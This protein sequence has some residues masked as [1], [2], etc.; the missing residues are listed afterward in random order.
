MELHHHHHHHHHHH[1]TIDGG[2]ISL[3]S[4]GNDFKH[5]FTKGNMEHAA[6]AA[7]PAFTT[8]VGGVMG[9]PLGAAAGAATGYL[10]DKGLQNAIHGTGYKKSH[11][12]YTDEYHETIKANMAAARSKKG[13]PR[14]RFVKGSQ[15]AR[16]HMAK[17]RAMRTSSQKHVTVRKKRGKKTNQE[18]DEWANGVE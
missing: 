16:D 4:I 13:P 10:A 7:I 1:A 8:S 12:M 5:T 15:E 2:K 18:W 17:L 6:Y 9:G 3:K 11:P 14:G